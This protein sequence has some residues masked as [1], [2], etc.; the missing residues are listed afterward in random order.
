MRPHR[1]EIAA[2]ALGLIVMVAACSGPGT[3][4]G[5]T[6]DSGPIKLAIV[7]GFTGDEASDSAAW[8]RGVEFAVKQ[9]NRDG[10][11]LKRRVKTYR[12]DS[13]SSPAKSVAAMKK[14]LQ[15]SPY[16]VFGT[17]FSA[18]TIV[19]EKYLGKQDVPQFTGSTNPDITNKQKPTHL[20]MAEPNAADEAKLLNRWIVDSADASRVAFIYS[21]DAYGVATKDSAV[22]LLKKAGVTVTSAVATKVGQTDFSGEIGKIRGERP[23]VLYMAMHEDENAKFLRQWK[24]AG[25]KGSAK[26]VG[27][28]TLLSSITTGLA[29]SAANGASGF[30]PYD[31]TAPS[32]KKLAKEYSKKHDGKNVDH[33]FLKAYIATWAMAY[34][35]REIGTVSQEK[36]I[37]WLH[38]RTM[39]VSKYPNLLESSHWDKYGNLERVTYLATV[40]NGSTKV[41]ENI[42]PLH[43]KLFKKCG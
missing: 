15:K 21:N 43:P 26:I 34:A 29:R 33:N 17:V 23:D 18:D 27:G 13:E 5:S 36:L 22:P 10:G 2:G 6:D 42:P 24:S 11:I 28:A 38:D 40:E 9:I 16:A 20:F 8:A 4:A 1:L 31:A 12:V 39:C 7:T 19:N 25:L 35:T 3:S 14:A 32:T 41:T 37:N 30:V